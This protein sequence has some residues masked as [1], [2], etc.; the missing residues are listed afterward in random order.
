MGL[1][2]NVFR[3]FDPGSENVFRTRRNRPIP[4]SEKGSQMK[5]MDAAALLCLALALTAWLSAAT[6]QA[7]ELKHVTLAVGTSVLNV[8]YPMLTLPLTLGYWKKEGYDVEVQ[9][10]GASLQAIQQMVAGNA[11]LAQVNASAIVQ[12]DVTNRLTVR[13]VMANGVTDWSIAVP[14]GSNIKSAADL[15]GKTIGVFSVA[16]AGRSLLQRYL[17]ANGLDLEAAGINLLPLGLGAAPVEALRKGEV[18]A[19]LY[20]AAATAGFRNAGLDLREIVPDDWRTY[21]DYSLSVMKR[22]AESDPDMVVGIARGI[23]KATVYA[24][25]N[26]TCAVK[27]HWQRYP[28]TKPA[29]IDEA[30]ALR[31]D[32]NSI[33]MQLAT[34]ED[35]FKLNG[36]R[37][38][39]AVDPAGFERLQAF[40]QDAGTIQGTLPATEYL[41][42]IPHLSDRINDFDADQ[43]RLAAKNCEVM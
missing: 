25:A 18:D 15:K 34:L 30:L 9:P 37:Q 2:E 16:S 39:G 35:G 3:V 32:L 42:A 17:K 29:G 23:A 22:T 8:S 1:A 36:G 21:P 24:L 33:N 40:L 11:D 14:V 4:Q 43:V 13:V 7:R 26:P 41:A 31:R 19:L 6:A 27:L 10:V 5:K 38:W 20:W 28:E 12:S